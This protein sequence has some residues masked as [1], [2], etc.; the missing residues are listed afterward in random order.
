MTASKLVPKANFSK[1]WPSTRR[2]TLL[3]T[4][5]SILKIGRLRTGQVMCQNLSFMM[6]PSSGI[7]ACLVEGTKVSSTLTLSATW[8][9]ARSLFPGGQLRKTLSSRSYSTSKKDTTPREDQSKSLASQ[10]RSMSRSNSRWRN[11]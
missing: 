9:I 8:A 5:S 7:K 6:Q 2:M 10:S 4:R 1:N 3:S 11:C